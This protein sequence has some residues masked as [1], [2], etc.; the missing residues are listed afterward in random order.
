MTLIARSQLLLEPN[1]LAARAIGSWLRTATDKLDSAAGEALLSRAELAVHEAC[2]NV[3]D[4]AH[5]PEGSQVELNL[6]LTTEWLTV[7]IFDDGD[8]FDP[9]T[10]P[11]PAPRV[12][13][14]RGYGMKIIR[15]LVNHVSYRRIGSR[16][17]LELRIYVGST[18]DRR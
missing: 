7:Q 9:A 13:Q 10:I 11:T 12:L 6:R 1:A 16:N 4:H 14:E 3:I 5:L 8:V 2:M 15:S 18:D 17:T